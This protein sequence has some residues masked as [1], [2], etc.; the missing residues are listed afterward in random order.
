MQ[1]IP[2]FQGHSYEDADVEQ[3]LEA[4]RRWQSISIFTLGVAAFLIHGLRF[5]E[6]KTFLYT[7][8]AFSLYLLLNSMLSVSPETSI[9]Y[10][11]LFC[12][13]AVLIAAVQLDAGD[14][15]RVFRI[16]SLALLV[17]LLAFCSTKSLDAYRHW[18][19]VHPNTLGTWALIT[20]IMARAWRNWLRWLG[21]LVPLYVAFKVESRFAVLGMLTFVMVVEFIDASRTRARWQ[22]PALLAAVVISIAAWDVI[23]GFFE[24]QGAR[25]L[26]EGISGRIELWDESLE[27]ISDQPVFGYGFRSTRVTENISH[28]G[29]LTLIEELGFVG[30][31]L[32]IGMVALRVTE[33]VR[34]HRNSE[35][36]DSRWLYSILLGGLVGNISPFL[37]QPNYFNFGDVLGVFVMFILFMHI[38]HPWELEAVPSSSTDGLK[39][40]ASW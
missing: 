20:V 1:V 2:F 39:H 26:D 35:N 28:S 22:I 32:F 18:G 36:P 11:V 6:N 4:A 23:G 27:R 30:L 29:L 40:T 7:I 8:W 16:A 3:L 9:F 15:L 10:S 13:V 31:I 14:W 17:A 24:Q 38:K 12:G 5:G 33:L 37:F 34:G 21:L 19:A 25:S